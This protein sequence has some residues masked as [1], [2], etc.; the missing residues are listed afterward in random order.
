MIKTSDNRLIRD[1]ADLLDVVLSSTSIDIHESAGDR[2]KRIK[3][4]LGNYE[5]FC[6]Y[7]FPEYCFAPFGWF[8]KIY[9]AE[10]AANPFNIY[11]EQYS[12]EFAKSTHFL[13]FV[14]LFLKAGGTLNGM[15][16]G[17]IT[18]DAAAEKLADLQA[19]LQANQRYIND[20]GEQK[21]YGNW[22]DGIFKTKDDTA[23][24]GFGK[25]QSP[26][27]TKFKW[28]RPDYGAIDDLND[29]RQLKNEVIANEDKRWVLEELKP[30]LWIKRWWLVILQNKFNDNAVTSLIQNDEHIKSIVHRVDI[31]NEKGHSN[32]PENFTD[33][34]IDKLEESEGAAFT[35]ERMN[36]PF[37]EGTVIKAEWL[38]HWITPLPLHKYDSALVHYLDPSYKST[39]TSDYKFWILLGKTGMFYDIL[40]A[41]GEKTDS[42]EMWQHAFDVDDE[43]S[44]KTTIK[45]VMEAGFIQELVHRAELTRVEK[46]NGRALAVSMDVR[47]KAHKLERIGTLAPLFK[48]GLIRFNILKK[49]SPGMKLL[50]KQ[51]IAIGEG[52]KVNDDGPDALE[53]GVWYTDRFGGK[54][55]KPSRSGKYNKKLGRAM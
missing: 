43:V 53:G 42:G 50:R 32:W 49:T 30:A 15:I 2:K 5:A 48:R 38:E 8:H 20:F 1:F 41:W 13:L 18:H 40:D 52:S 24:Y 16:L 22:E 25:G 3:Y 47:K 17:S 55:R 44:G 14:P 33:E 45:H 23:F 35:R 9:P 31:R 11:L 10:V 12:R 54:D 29:A 4:L 34:E 27:G 51:L 6:L 46:D 37:D 7:Y 21:T 36:T 26:R 39:E 28:K 19:N